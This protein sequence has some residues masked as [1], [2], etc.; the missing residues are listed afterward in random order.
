[1]T[2]E[3]LV[4]ERI[5]GDTYEEAKNLSVPMYLGLVAMLVEEKCKDEGLDVVDVLQRVTN[6]ASSIVEKYGRY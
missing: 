6:T 2:D 5:L 1:M 3:I 4:V